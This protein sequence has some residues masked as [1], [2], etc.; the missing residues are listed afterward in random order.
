MFVVMLLTGAAAVGSAL[1]AGRY[2]PWMGTAFKVGQEHAL[3]P[4][5]SLPA[6]ALGYWFM[7]R[8][9]RAES[10]RIYEMASRRRDEGGPGTDP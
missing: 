8:I 6:L 5:A 10:L 3:A 4:V 7:F 2:V 1:L 9:W